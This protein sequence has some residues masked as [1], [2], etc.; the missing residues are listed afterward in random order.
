MSGDRGRRFGF[1]ELLLFAFLSADGSMMA[2]EALGLASGV[3]LP[4]LEGNTLTG[5][6]LA[7]P[8]D[9]LGRP[10]ILVIGFSKAAAKTS[11]GWLEGCRSAAAAK[12]SSAVGCYDVRM[13]AEVPRFFRGMVE[14]SMRN[15]YPL[16]LQRQT[17]LVYS[18]SDAWREHARGIDD[19]M[20][21]VIACDRD[22]RVR[23]T[24]AGAFAEAEMKR[25]L[26]VI[27]PGRDP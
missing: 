18:E 21:Y 14:R 17:L 24:A 9:A 12:S 1:R 5:E 27:E 2:G 3:E 16:D 22:G 7:L 20:S 10:A 26:E 8:R 19:K 23:G 6:A 13:L 11:R 4:R 25:L 15:G